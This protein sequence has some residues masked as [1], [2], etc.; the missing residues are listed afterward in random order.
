MRNARTRKAKA[1]A[2]QKQTDTQVVIGGFA[3]LGV[4]LLALILRLIA[5]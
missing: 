1:I 5:A 4:T 2:I 3:L